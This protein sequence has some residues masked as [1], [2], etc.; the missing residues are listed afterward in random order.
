MAAM[1]KT[2]TSRS[3]GEF[4]QIGKS[5]FASSIRFG[6]H[7]IARIVVAYQAGLSRIPASTFLGMKPSEVKRVPDITLDISQFKSS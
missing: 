1:V 5:W 3:S 7:Q 6:F 4:H 2:I